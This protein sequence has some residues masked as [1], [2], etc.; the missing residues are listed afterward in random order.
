MARS[1]LDGHA[2]YTEIWDHKPPG[3]AVLFAL[4]QLVFGRTVLSIRILAW[5]AVTASSLLLFLLG[6]SLST[7]TT[8]I[9]RRILCTRSF[10]YDGG[11]AS[12]VEIFFTP[13]LL[14]TLFLALSYDAA[15]L[16][17]RPASALALGVLAG[18]A[19][20][21]QY[22]VA[23]TW[24]PSSS[25]CFPRYGGEEDASGR[26][27]MLRFAGLAAPGPPLCSPSSPL[28]FVSQGHFADYFDA[29]F[30]ANAGYVADRVDFLNS[31]GW[32]SG[33][34]RAF[35]LWLALALAPCL[36]LAPSLD[37]PTRRGLA[38]GCCGPRSLSRHLR[39]MRR[40]LAHYFLELLPAHCAC[41]RALLVCSSV[42][43]GSGAHAGET[44]ILLAFVFL[45]LV[46]RA[47]EMPIA[48]TLRT[49]QYRYVK[50]VDHWGD[51]PALVAEYLAT[52]GFGPSDYLY[53][54]DQLPI[55]YYL[56]PFADSHRGF[57]FRRT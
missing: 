10:R 2:L 25:F 27:G 8:G 17:D 42:D 37:S 39:D 31:A 44:A 55:L 51:V 57:L 35:P 22:I 3:I 47:A 45:G 40:L 26:L 5:F 29:N 28:W 24:P 21:M 32:S 41:S 9:G 13:L 20:Q 1:V 54:V 12:N 33:G 49:V 36:A 48:L 6:R 11:L 15:E 18:L 7:T 43:V 52:K 30:A 23:S 53:V 14:L 19:A 46:L 38:A 56:V 4:G 16:L 34:S 50:G